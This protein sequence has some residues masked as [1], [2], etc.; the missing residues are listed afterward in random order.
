MPALC[1]GIG[2]CIKNVLQIPGIYYYLHISSGNRGQ[3]NQSGVALLAQFSVEIVR[4][5]LSWEQFSY[6]TAQPTGYQ[7]LC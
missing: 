1:F 7:K 2:V 4:F 3:T 5:A 6:M